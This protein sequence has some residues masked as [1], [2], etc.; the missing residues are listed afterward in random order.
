MSMIV[1]TDSCSGY[2]FPA[3]TKG[4]SIAGGYFSGIHAVKCTNAHE[5]QDP[6]RLIIV[7]ARWVE[8][9]IEFQSLVCIPSYSITK[10]SVTLHGDGS[11][12]NV[13]L[14]T[15]MPANSSALQLPNVKPM[16]IAMG[17]SASL[18]ASK[19]LIS[20]ANPFFWTVNSTDTSFY[21]PFIQVCNFTSPHL[22]PAD[23]LEE[24]FLY[25]ISRQTF[26]LISA[27]I[28]KKSLMVPSSTSFLGIYAA[29]TH[30]LFVR[31]L[32][33]RIMEG[34]L[35]VLVLIAGAL[36]KFRS[37]GSTPRD[38]GTIT[39]LAA[40][41]ARSSKLLD[42]LANSGAARLEDIK[43]ILAGNSYRTV[44][45]KDSSFAIEQYSQDPIKVLPHSAISIRWWAPF[46]VTI[47]ARA[48]T[49]ITPLALIAALEATYQRS[50]HQNGLAN[51]P[52]ETYIKYTWVYIPAFIMLGTA[53]IFDAVH[54]S[55][56]VFHPYSL[57]KRG[58]VSVQESMTENYIS[59]VTI[60][61]F[62][63]AF[64]NRHYVIFATSF[65]MLLAP[66]LTVTVS[67]LYSAEDVKYERQGTVRSLDSFNSTIDPTSGVR[68]FGTAPLVGSLV[69]G[70]GLP[71]P[72]WT[73]DELLF[74]TLDINSIT[75][76]EGNLRTPSVQSVSKTTNTT[77]A[78]SIFVATVPALRASL[79]CQPLP[80]A[81][82][83][84]AVSKT[85]IAIDLDIGTNCGYSGFSN[86]TMDNVTAI[87]SN[88]KPDAHFG[89]VVN[90]DVGGGGVNC[91][92]FVSVYGKYLDKDS[93]IS[94]FTCNTAVERVIVNV[95]F[96]LP[97]F[98]INS[99]TVDETSA[100]IFAK[101][102]TSQLALG[103][104]LFAKNETNDVFDPFY[105]T[106]IYSLKTLTPND[107]VKTEFSTIVNASQHLYRLLM[108]Q[109]LNTKSRVAIPEPEP[110]NIMRGIL[111]DPTVL[112]LKQSPI[113]T[114]ILEIILAVM[115]L[116]ALA[117]FIV[118][119][120]KEVLP[121]NPCSIA[122]S[123]SLLAGS[124]MMNPDIIPPGSEWLNDKAL[125]EQGL[126]RGLLFS[127]GWWGK[128]SSGEKRF[129]IDVGRAE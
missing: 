73:Y 16:D 29:P 109:V 21:D 87:I 121:K 62:C 104:L 23:F 46:S 12:I 55:A 91:P 33:L 15:P 86:G 70:G 64:L 81:N 127:L 69:I 116:C 58:G 88:I 8:K 44:V 36:C 42:T 20:L 92:D 24:D 95:T 67:G 14:N 25:R 2:A 3:F 76:L 120:T 52:G 79:K 103:N 78:S 85:M 39:G 50:R 75:D 100:T 107:L 35:A 99:T 1:V 9:I 40:I 71:Y 84:L 94:A 96:L 65:A 97:E 66:M 32:S 117:V 27:Q 43:I 30:R 83:S 48:L 5:E 93:K 13:I 106:L 129:G 51:V 90:T 125:M 110:N 111:I 124:E 101:N 10:G 80:P 108:A 6:D 122:A 77:G 98:R 38:P 113:S 89:V 72:A 59:K 17:L 114:R 126:F 49:L 7:T 68:G 37:S 47:F 18:N 74:P 115:F 4:S 61:S 34:T 19:T 22:N 112:R 31:E 53:T 41:L 63:S 11:V 123:A 118:M 45:D 102:L 57:L 56:Q 54:F 60:H 128:G 119:D 26:K 105:S 28:A 82:Y